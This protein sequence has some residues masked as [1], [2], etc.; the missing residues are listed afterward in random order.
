MEIEETV[1][2]GMYIVERPTEHQVAVVLI[3][4]LG[5]SSLC[6]T[7]AFS[8]LSSDWHL[9][10]I[11]LPGYGRSPRGSF[12]G[13]IHGYVGCL[14]S[15]INTYLG[16]KR[17]IV[18]GHSFG[19]DI[20]NLLANTSLRVAAFASIE[21][22][23]TPHDL[24]ISRRAVNAPSFSTWFQ[25]FKEEMYGMGRESVAFRRYFVSL[26]LAD[27]R[28]F[29][30]SARSL[31]EAVERLGPAFLNIRGPKRFFWGRKSLARETRDFVERHNI[32]NE[33]FDSGHWVMIDQP[34]TFYGKLRAFILASIS[35]GDYR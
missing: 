34:E 20:G 11:D 8:Q 33:S 7:E 9:L 6:W 5:E 10:A 16:S 29:I 28:I 26:S 13:T 30:K 31:M 2:E 14:E 32:P 17:I 27:P 24:F 19:G 4:G 12:D 21:G 1:K 15:L 35:E 22:D 23:L 18:V 3:H 25:E